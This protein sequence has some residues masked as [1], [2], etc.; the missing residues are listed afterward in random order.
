MMRG[1]LLELA[2]RR[3][4]LVARAQA[5]RESVGRLLAATDGFSSAAGALMGVARGALNQALRHP[6]FTAIGLLAFFLLRPRRAIGWLAKGWSLWRLFRSAQGVWLRFA[7][8]AGAPP[9]PGR[10]GQ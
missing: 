5:E 7:A 10:Y 9:P 2:E 8:T 6:L 3:A 1:R 4:H